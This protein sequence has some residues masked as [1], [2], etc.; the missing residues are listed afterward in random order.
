MSSSFSSS[1]CPPRS[2]PTRS[3]SRCDPLSESESSAGN[4][5]RVRSSYH[6]LASRK[7]GHWSQ[8]GVSS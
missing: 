3:D 4:V 6:S 8:P 2:D 1:N 5:G 7:S